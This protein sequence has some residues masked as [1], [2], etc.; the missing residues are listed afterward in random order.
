MYLNFHGSFERSPYN[1]AC[2]ISNQTLNMLR[3]WGSWQA[4]RSTGG[5]SHLGGGSSSLDWRVTTSLQF[6]CFLRGPGCPGVRSCWV[7]SRTLWLD[8]CYFLVMTSHGF[9]RFHLSTCSEEALSEG[10]MFRVVSTNTPR[11]CLRSPF[12]AVVPSL[13]WCVGMSLP[14]WSSPSLNWGVCGAGPPSS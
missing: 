12:P 13:Y 1:I 5:S 4:F 8:L 11:V 6:L 10:D 9:L 2:F 3:V 7:F 14:R